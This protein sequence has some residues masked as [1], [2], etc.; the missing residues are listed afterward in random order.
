MGPLARPESRP[1]IVAHRGVRSNEWEE[2]TPA[3][4]TAA[5]KAGADWVELDA[6]RS[7]DGVAVLYHNGWTPDGL[8]VVDRTAAELA[9]AGLAPLDKVLAGL[10]EGMGVDLE[11]KNLPGEPDYDPD[12]GIVEIVAEVVRAAPQRPMIVSSFNPL[13]VASLVRVLPEVPACLVHFDSL[14]VTVAMNIA[15]QQ[16]AVALCSRVRSPGLDAQGVAA[17]HAAGLSIL[18]WTVNDVPTAARL[19]TAGVDGM[20]TDRPDLLLAAMTSDAATQPR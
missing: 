13:T 8:P 14:P 3:A 2:N 17:V 1:L 20:V 16:G 9:D 7:A 12:D 11:V 5:H 15:I 10:P 19:A 4:F 6:R 18:V